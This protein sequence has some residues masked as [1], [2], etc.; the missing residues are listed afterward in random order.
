MKRAAEEEEEENVGGKKKMRDD[1]LLRKYRRFVDSLTPTVPAEGVE[2]SVKAMVPESVKMILKDLHM[3]PGSA[4]MKCLPEDSIVTAVTKIVLDEVNG[5]IRELVHAMPLHVDIF[6]KLVEKRQHYSPAITMYKEMTENM[7]PPAEGE[8][9]FSVFAEK[10]RT[11]MKNI[12]KRV[13]SVIQNNELT[14]NS[15]IMSRT[16]LSQITIPTKTKRT[17]CK[18]LFNQISTFAGEN[19]YTFF[20]EDDKCIT[21]IIAKYVL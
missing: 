11:V 13:A 17:I 18:H 20:I 1:K 14:I 5:P 3:E 6:N 19:M 21:K 4:F 15:N 2:P 10:L 8:E 16:I 7:Q 12:I 9:S